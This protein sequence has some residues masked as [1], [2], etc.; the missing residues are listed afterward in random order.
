M[1]H[2]VNQGLEILQRGILYCQTNA[3]QQITH[4]E[5]VSSSFDVTKKNHIIQYVIVFCALCIIHLAC[6]KKLAF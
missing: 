4:T 1:E 5:P 6:E 3:E 2:N